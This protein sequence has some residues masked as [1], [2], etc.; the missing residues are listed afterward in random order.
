MGLE[1]HPVLVSKKLS[2]L[3]LGLE[4]CGL[5]YNT[6]SNLIVVSEVRGRRRKRDVSRWKKTMRKRLR[7][8]GQEYTSVSGKT[9]ASK[10]RHRL[11]N[12][13]CPLKCAEKLSDVQ[14]DKIFDGFWALKS[15]SLQNAYLCGLVQQR[16][17]S[18]RYTPKGRDSRRSITR[19][20]Y[21]S[22]AD[23][24]VRVCKSMF[25]ST[26]DISNGRLQRALKNQL[27]AGHGS[28]IIDQRGRHTPGNK[29]PQSQN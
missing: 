17:V 3:G 11:E 15:W 1:K 24:C 14:L 22:S 13:T 21:L 2:G 19:Y 27:L 28:P 7:N 18:R 25:L 20:Y 10:T 5:D 29:T 16:A 4:A 23:G 12:H 8:S 26:L 9:V 6:D